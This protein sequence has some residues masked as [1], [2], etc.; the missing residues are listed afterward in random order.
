MTMQPL[1]ATAAVLATAIGLVHSVLGERLVFRHLRQSALVPSL[2]AP[3]LQER[4]VRIL[5]AT[6]HLASVF[7]WTLAGLLWQ[8]AK[9]PGL[10]LPATSVLSAS[11]FGFLVGALLVLVGTRGRHPGWIALGAVGILSWAAIGAA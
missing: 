4:N 10:A 6:W 7:G 3:P 8:V 1:V 11:A 9:D 5:W 2:P